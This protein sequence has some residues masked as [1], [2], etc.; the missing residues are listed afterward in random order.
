MVYAKA[1][2]HDQHSHI[3]PALQPL[4]EQG[5]LTPLKIGGRTLLPIVQGGMGVGVS[6]HSLAGTVASCG[7]IGTIASVDLRHLH[8]D[9]AEQTRRVRGEEGKALIEAANQEALRMILK[10]KYQLKI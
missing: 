3:L 6:A 10:K 2:L 9:L 8:T 7:G 1:T 4:L 5:A